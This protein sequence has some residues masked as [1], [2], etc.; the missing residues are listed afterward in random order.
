MRSLHW[1]ASPAIAVHL[2]LEYPQSEVDCMN[3]VNLCVCFAMVDCFM[4]GN[5]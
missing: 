1:E 2:R 5:Q 4:V 3:L